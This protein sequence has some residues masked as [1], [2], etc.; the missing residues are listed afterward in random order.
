MADLESLI[1][2]RN[3][4]LDEKKKVLGNLFKEIE[5]LNLSKRNLLNNLEEEKKISQ[6]DMNLET[7]SF[8]GA[9]AESVMKK[10]ELI[11]T[12]L[13]NLET[14]IAIAQE[15]VRSSFAELKKIEITDRNRKDLEL[16]E[17]N[18]KE[19]NDLDE[20]GLNIYSRKDN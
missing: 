8:F 16:K 6:K 14:R 15:D 5:K 7:N 18:R 11:N 4:Q 3:H 20:M 12:A 2:Y 9:Y 1:K 10:V 17:S 19:N 13:Q